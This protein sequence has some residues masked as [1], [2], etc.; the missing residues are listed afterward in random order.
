[1]ADLPWPEAIKNDSIGVFDRL[2]AS[3]HSFCKRNG[4]S[5]SDALDQPDQKKDAQSL[6]L[7]I[8][9]SFQTHPDAE[10]HPSKTNRGTL[11]DDLLRVISAVA[12]DNFD[13]D[14]IKPLLNALLVNTSDSEIWKL[15]YNAVFESTPPPRPV[16]SSLLQT[17]LRHNTSSLANSSEQRE[18]MDRA[19]KAE[20]GP[21]YVGLHKFHETYFGAVVDLEK[22]S[23]AFFNQ[24]MGD[25]DPLFD[26]GW[27]GWPKDA[28]QDDVLHWLESFCEKLAS[29]AES[30]KSSPVGQRALLTQPNTLVKGSVARRKMDLGFVNLKRRGGKALY[31]SDVLVPGELKS[32]RNADGHLET[33]IDLARYTREV[34]ASQDTRRFV[35]GFTICGSLMRV[36]EFDR[37]GAI[38]SESF[39]INSDGLRFVY[40]VLGFLWMSREQLGFD[41]TIISTSDEKYIVIERN[42]VHERLIIDRMMRPAGCIVG[43]ATT[44]WKAHRQGELQTPL[45]IKDSW[46]YPEREEEGELL[47]KAT[48]RGVINVARYYHHETV[49]VLDTDD[50]VQNSVRKGLDIT[51]AEKHESGSSV[52]SPSADTI[53]GQN[54]RSSTA[55]SKRPSSHIDAPLPPSKRSCSASRTKMDSITPLNRVHRRVVLRDYG[56]PIYYA[57]SRVAL[58]K[59]LE[60]CIKG[61]ESLHKAGLLHRDI[62]INNLMINEDEKNPSWPS[63]LIDLDLAIDEQ[64]AGS[65]GANGRT[66][67]RAFMAIGVLQGEQHSFMHDLES[68]FWVL[69]W[70]CVHY[71]GP[72]RAKVFTQFDKSRYDAWNFMDFENLAVFKS[73]QIGHEAD[74]IRRAGKH[75]TPYYRPLIPWVNRLRRVVFPQDHRW[76]RQDRGLYSQM[77]DVLRE[78]WKELEGY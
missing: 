29:F 68:F 12:S 49:R 61:H 26:N 8:L 76:E 59:A 38:A 70:I 1:M 45:V 60:G 43:R 53:G 39:D 44:C 41:P 24:C 35:L 51:K 57:S 15:V 65:S 14:R 75:F 54:G 23:K 48:D 3:C 34:F 27:R 78:A 33:W 40:T 31:W 4:I 71:E 6:V 7:S 46:Q 20:L 37:V 21:I 52:R 64:R 67:T 10:E 63:F 22:A 58:L 9:V 28:K 66:G 62:S 17:P 18:Y 77:T 32:N 73:G 56:K 30:Y 72:G 16:V 74:F 47:R 69:F 2:R 42:G 36:F 19:L 55:G 13:F 5:C 25:S 11:R 50:D